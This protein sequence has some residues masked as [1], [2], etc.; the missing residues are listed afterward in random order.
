MK[1]NDAWFKLDNAAKIYP[2][3]SIK[4][5]PPQFRLTVSLEKP[6]NYHFFKQAWENLLQRCPYFQVYLKR[7]LF[8]Y[9]LQKHDNIPS[10]EL[11]K[12]VPDLTFD[13]KKRTSHLLKATLRGNTIALD[14]S[15]ILTDGNGGM[16]FLQALIFE[17]FK[18]MK[19]NVDPGKNM[20]FAGSDPRK[21]EYEDAF[22]KFFPGK[23]P[24]PDRLKK[25]FHL[26]GTF[27]T[28]NNFRIISGELSLD[29]ILTTS[30]NLHVSITEYLT[31][32]YLSSL[33]KIFLQEKSKRTTVLRLEVPVDLRRYYDTVTM[34]NFSLYNSIE[35][36][37]KLGEYSFTDILKKVHHSMRLQ[38]DRKELNRQ[39]SRNVRGETNPFIR[40][41]PIIM[42]N[43]Y[44]AELY[45][46]L[47]ERCY[48]GVISNLGPIALPEDFGSHIESFNFI[49]NPNQVMK[50]SITL[51]SWQEILRINIS[52]VIKDRELERLFFTKL[53][54]DGIEVKIKET[55]NADLS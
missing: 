9:Y 15:H 27:F 14:F 36:D 11:M 1:N 22:L 33:L 26:S 8:W 54:E 51:L 52:S 35:I 55:Q 19:I 5:S 42:K 53:T 30:R 40:I 38:T 48:S 6:V 13:H 37:L 3:L 2:A 29:N 50:K 43:I 7:G 49:L 46:R 10:I 12:P 31:A 32:V 17:Y 16:R 34:R 47:G 25:A 39:V 18:L 44:M 4:K 21:E 28:N 20:L 45:S 24:K 23:L 41:V